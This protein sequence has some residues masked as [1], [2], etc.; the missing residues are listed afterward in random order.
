MKLI[1]LFFALALFCVTSLQAQKKEKLDPISMAE[2]YQK[3]GRDLMN[4]KQFPEAVAALTKAIDM[5][6]KDTEVYYVRGMA[7]MGDKNQEKAIA[8]FTTYIN[9]NGKDKKGA[10]FI[11]GLCK[12]VIKDDTACADLAKAKELGVKTEWENYSIICGEL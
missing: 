10:Y 4:S 8:D 3:E 6:D 7:Y 9:N 12:I 1:Q 11:R 5:W 2:Q